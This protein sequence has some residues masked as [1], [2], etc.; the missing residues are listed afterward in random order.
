M[1]DTQALLGALQLSD[2]SLP[3]GRFV[4]SQGVEAWLNDRPDVEPEQIVSLTVSMAHAVARVDGVFLVAAI[5]AEEV[6][7]LLD[8]DLRLTARKTLPSA[9]TMSTTCG[10]Q[11]ATLG[12]RMA[13]SDLLS[14][15]VAMIERRE[16]DGNLAVVSG[17]L[18][19]ALGIDPAT[20]VAVELRSAASAVLSVA[21]RLGRL[22]PSLA[23]EQLARMRP[24]LAHACTLALTTPLADAF[25]SMP[26]LEVS[27]MAHRRADYRFFTT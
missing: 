13:E 14:L 7:V 19:G 12:P 27:A 21:V 11:L 10:R 26:E 6:A 8:L 17:A 3:I 5:R 24:E 15:Y 23:Q 1:T 2:S 16:T 18:S 25:A 22:S 4:H 9:R 20:A